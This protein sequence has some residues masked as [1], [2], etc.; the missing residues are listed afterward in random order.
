MNKYFDY[1]PLSISDLLS[2]A[3]VMSADSFGHFTRAIAK[4]AADGTSPN[5]LPADAEIVFDLYRAKIYDAWAIHKMRGEI[6]AKNGR[7]GGVAKAK[8]AKAKEVKTAQ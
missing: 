8:N 5:N 2:A 4:Y 1:L 7:R 3:R 6:N